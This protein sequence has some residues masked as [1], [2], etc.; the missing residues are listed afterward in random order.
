MTNTNK[1][2]TSEEKK[3]LQKEAEKNN[4][5]KEEIEDVEN[6]LKATGGM[7]EGAQKAFI[8][9]LAA[10]SGAALGTGVTYAIMK[11]NKK[12]N[13][14]QQNCV[15]IKLPL[16]E[17]PNGSSSNPENGADSRNL[18]SQLLSNLSPENRA[19]ISN[20]EEGAAILRALGVKI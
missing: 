20:T 14:D 2:L 19:A 5:S 1:Q 4:L 6:I 16:G 11:H 7:S 3:L 15:T 9:I 17:S 18:V 10:V 13:N 8:G 12:S